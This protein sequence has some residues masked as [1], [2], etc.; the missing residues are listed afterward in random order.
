LSDDELIAAATTA[1]ASL[2]K[3]RDPA[4]LESGARA[5]F[6][7]IDGS[8]SLTESLSTPESVYLDGR[9]QRCR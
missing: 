3:L 6:L 1:P 2:W 8:R 7:L 9:L 4:A 5:S